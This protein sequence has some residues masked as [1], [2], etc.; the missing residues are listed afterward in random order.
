MFTLESL[1]T[2]SMQQRYGITGIEVTTRAKHVYNFV[3]ERN[4]L[5]CQAQP[6]LVFY[7]KN[8]RIEKAMP[9]VV[10]GEWITGSAGIAM[11]RIF[12]ECAWDAIGIESYIKK[13]V[14]DL[15]D[16]ELVRG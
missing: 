8:A 4:K 3:D 13:T 1:F 2:I 14:A 12:A 5:V 9:M 10:K 16:N 6:V 15:R 7:F 11:K